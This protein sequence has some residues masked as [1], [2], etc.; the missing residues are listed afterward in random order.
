VRSFVQRAAGYSLTGDTSEQVLFICYGGGAN[1][2]TTYQEAKAAA[3]GDYA[4]RAPT[5]ML[6]AKRPGGIPNDVA[7]LKGSRFVAASETEDGRRLAE[8]MVK[9]LTGQ[10]TI[11]ARF[12]RGEFFDFAPTHKL[13]L[14]TNHK[15]TIVGTDTAIWRRI[16]LIPWTV[17]IPPAEQDKR[18]LARLRR[19]E[20]PG[21]LAWM[22][23][24]CLA[25]QR[26]GLHDPDEVLRATSDYR[27][28]MDVLA[29]FLS[30]CCEE[31]PNHWDYARDL[32][33]SYK[34]WCD[35]N[36][37]RAEAQRKFGGRLGERGFSRDRGGSRGA[38]IWRGVR[39]T[40]E[41]KDRITGSSEEC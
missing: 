21:I 9:D 33:A 23:R 34:R 19:D 31:D 7:R 15:P 13:W 16:R 10:D 18:L 24:G 11:T 32:Y 3:L 22:V 8:S 30:D 17:T 20:L 28:E 25:W 36:G 12:M 35:E 41:E 5:E 29:G 2:K 14:S 26:E 38:H 4:M 1:G 40:E 6:L 37:E 27:R 39:L